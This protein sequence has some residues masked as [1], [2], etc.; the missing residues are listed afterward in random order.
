[1]KHSALPRSLALILALLA[2]P[3]PLVAGTVEASVGRLLI[4]P[5]AEGFREPW[6]LAFLP[7]GG[8]LV[9]ER[10]G[11]L[12]RVGPDG[13]RVRVGGTPE[14]W[15]RGQGGLL[16]VMVPRDFATSR[17]VFLSFSK[18]QPGGAGTALAV[19]RLNADG[20]ALADL[21][22]IFEM[23]PGG[24]RGQHFGSRIVEGAEG[25]IFLTIGDRGE[26]DLAQDNSR[27]NGTVVRLM[28]DG[29]VPDDNPF[30]GVAGAR[31][32]I[33]SYG[34]RNAQG[35][36]LG[37]DGALWLVEHGAMGGD[38][39]NRVEPG[40]N[41]G[42]PVIAYGRNYNGTTIGIGTE[43]EGM[44]QPVHY[45]DP[46]IAPSGLAVYSGA[47][48]PDWAGRMLVG[49]LKFDYIAVLDPA[50]G[51]EEGLRTRETARVRDVREA[52]DGSI[53]FLSVGREGVFRISPAP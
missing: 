15:V 1:M 4:A 18:P 32:E 27:H 16:D 46:S 35:A 17:E 5:V 33:W 30:T 49:S 12:W 38:E 41:F 2:G 40:V 48:W 45:W 14:V 52:P 13:E 8:F 6:G 21:R 20:D 50:T 3:A 47:L 44:A 31:P 9:T 34:H 25:H 37:P 11:T 29:T 42:W 22:V 36:A 7:D 26:A 53:W 43:A 19:G 10:G 39:V 23:T 24:G 28:R 51:D